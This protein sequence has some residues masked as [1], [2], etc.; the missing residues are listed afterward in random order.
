MLEVYER[1][2]HPQCPAEEEGDLGFLGL[3]EGIVWP[4]PCLMTQKMRLAIAQRGFWSHLGI[5]DHVWR[6][7]PSP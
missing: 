7:L 3:F 6:K 1:P 4:I 2:G 5:A